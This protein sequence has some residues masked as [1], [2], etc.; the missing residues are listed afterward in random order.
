METAR[1]FF[2]GAAYFFWVIG[3]FFLVFAVAAGMSAL[4]PAAVL[5]LVGLVFFLLHRFTARR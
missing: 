1:V 4:I 5:I 3:A 2:I